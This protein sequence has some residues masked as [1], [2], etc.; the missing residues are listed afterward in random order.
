[1]TTHYPY[2]KTYDWQKWQGEMFKARHDPQRPRFFNEDDEGFDL[3]GT[4][5]MH[6]SNMSVA[7]S[8]ET[9]LY[10]QSRNLVLTAERPDPFGFY[11]FV[12]ERQDAIL[13]LMTEHFL[14]HGGGLCFHPDD[15]DEPSTHMVMYGEWVGPGVQSGVGL[16]GLKEKWWVPF[17]YTNDHRTFYPVNPTRR[18]DLR[19]AGIRAIVPAHVVRY[20]WSRPMLALDAIK[21][22]VQEV[23]DD[24][25]VARVLGAEGI[26][27]GLVYAAGYQDWTWFKAKG[28][29]H[30][31]HKVRG[32]DN[33]KARD[34]TAASAFVNEHLTLERLAGAYATLR[35]VHGGLGRD[36]TREFM[37]ACLTDFVDE[38]QHL[39]DGLDERAVR[40]AAGAVAAQYYLAR[41]ETP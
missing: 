3:V 6:G 18:D 32:I 38:T 31:E 9:G 15:R 41:L 2:P 30:T 39:F 29:K 37:G 21:A 13:R 20:E 36:H 28:R 17:C 35:E 16:A 40:K 23:E 27:E 5:K 33:A 26:G 25:P 4:V 12:Q 14:A 11:Q 19:I 24:C 10:A 34:N 7:L 8:P 1:M 22:R